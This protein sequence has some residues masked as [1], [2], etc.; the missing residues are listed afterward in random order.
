MEVTDVINMG[1]INILDA[2]SQFSVS[3]GSTVQ[4]DINNP[5]NHTINNIL[6]LPNLLMDIMTI[7]RLGQKDQMLKSMLIRFLD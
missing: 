1:D 3:S 7:L 2:P 5:T 4:S 6:L